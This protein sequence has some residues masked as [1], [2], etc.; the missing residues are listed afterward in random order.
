MDDPSPVELQPA[1]VHRAA[2]PEAIRQCL[3]HQADLGWF[4]EME[5]DALDLYMASDQALILVDR[6]PIISTERQAR[7]RPCIL[8]TMGTCLERR[9]EVTA[10]R[11]SVCLGLYLG[12]LG[13]QRVMLEQ[14]LRLRHGVLQAKVLVIR[15]S[16]GPGP[17]LAHVHDA[18]AFHLLGM[19]HPMSADGP[20]PANSTH[21]TGH[22]RTRGSL[23]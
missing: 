18:T 22:L 6:V 12:E 1:L 11:D 13:S 20:P 21:R 5:H 19:E 17:Q 7:F 14:Y 23:P 15:R 8:S 3:G 10:P 9:G 2:R 4:I 16:E